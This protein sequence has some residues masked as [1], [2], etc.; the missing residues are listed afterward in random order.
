MKVRSGKDK[1]SQIL[2]TFRAVTQPSLMLNV[3][4]FTLGFQLAPS[5]CITSS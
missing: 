2:H 1:L 5:I 3:Y 4:F